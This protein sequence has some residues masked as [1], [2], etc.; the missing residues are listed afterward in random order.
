M[1]LQI[2]QLTCKG[3]QQ[4]TSDQGEMVDKVQFVHHVSA[5]SREK[6]TFLATDLIPNTQYN[7]SIQT[8]ACKQASAPHDKLIF[9]TEPGSK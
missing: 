6:E 2:L 9:M 4:Y 7:C 8:V 5:T 1:C 3:I